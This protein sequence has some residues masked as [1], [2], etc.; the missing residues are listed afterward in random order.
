MEDLIKINLLYNKKNI[1]I[2]LPSTYNEFLNLLEDK[3]YLT[4]E[5]LES[6]MIYYYDKDGDKNIVSKDNYDESKNE[7]D[8]NY[9]LEIDFFSKT[10]TP[11]NDSDEE[12]NDYKQKIK[13]N[14]NELKEIEEKIAKK[15]VKILEEKLKKK[16]LEYK[17]EIYNIKENLEN[18][19]KA[20]IKKN[21]K[22]FSDISKYYD[23]KM[24]E[25]FQKYNE[26]IINNLNKSISQSNL[27]E[28]MQEFFNNENLGEQDINGNDDNELNSRVFSA[29]LNN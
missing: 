11:N 25:N 5:L 18:T 29:V 16:D 4:P 20:I 24:K 23:E 14:K 2:E 17:N 19:I 22:E 9:E 27:N 28:L 15:Y 3:L 1:E 10:K 13:L 8:G 6:A 21:E 12:N 26:M 7:N